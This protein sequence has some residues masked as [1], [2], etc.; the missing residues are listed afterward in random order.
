[1]RG[2]APRSQPVAPPTATG[3]QA[4]PHR[5]LCSCACQALL[6]VHPSSRSPSEATGSARSVLEETRRQCQEEFVQA[7]RALEWA[8]CWLLSPWRQQAAFVLSVATCSASSPNFTSPPR[9]T[10]CVL[11]PHYPLRPHLLLPGLR[12]GKTPRP[13]RT[14]SMPPAWPCNAPCPLHPAAQVHA[15]HRC[16]PPVL[17][18]AAMLGLGLRHVISFVVSHLEDTRVGCGGR[19]Q[20]GSGRGRTTQTRSAEMFTFRERVRCPPRHP[21]HSTPPC[22]HPAPQIVSPDVQTRLLSTILD[23]VQVGWAGRLCLPH[24]C[25]L[26][27]FPAVRHARSP[28]LLHLSNPSS[29]CCC[30][31]RQPL[32]AFNPPSFFPPFLPPP[33]PTAQE[34]D[35]LQELG[36]NPECRRLLLPAMMRLFG[37]QL[38]WA[39]ASNF[40]ALLVEGCGEA[41]VGGGMAGLPLA[42]AAP[43]PGS[44]YLRCPTNIPHAP[45]LSPARRTPRLPARPG[46]LPARICGAPG[47]PA[48]AVQGGVPGRWGRGQGG[49]G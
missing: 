7:L 33:N 4:E 27:S 37:R 39:P 10:W 48:G 5:K 43:A 6:P 36:D 42:P 12:A 3:A 20:A 35:L 23:G 9:W 14:S 11:G 18:H 41:G 47:P 45:L 26:H 21:E 29:C 19:G 31:H 44:P 1:M 16:E 2:G 32:S 40:F 28:S 46:R 17:D 38:L 8:Q 15:V 49:A 34:L 30:I 24:A 13:P 25:C 22:R